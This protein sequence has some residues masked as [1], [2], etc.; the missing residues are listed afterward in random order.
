MRL[1]SLAVG[2]FWA[3]LSLPAVYLVAEKYIKDI[4][5]DRFFA[6]T[7][8]ISDW[9]MFIAL[10]QTPRS[11][12]FEAGAGFARR[13]RIGGTSASPLLPMLVCTWRTGCRRS[14]GPGSCRACLIRCSSPDGFRFSGWR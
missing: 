14:T 10:A 9:L 6:I 1:P 2:F 12:F 5:G 13:G 7:G 3:L 4:P 8:E 11:E